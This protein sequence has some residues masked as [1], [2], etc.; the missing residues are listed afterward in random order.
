MHKYR[1][2]IFRLRRGRII[3]KKSIATNCDVKSN[4]SLTFCLPFLIILSAYIVPV[5]GSDEQTEMLG[6]HAKNSDFALTT[7]KCQKIN[8]SIFSE[9]VNI[10]ERETARDFSNTFL[11]RC[12]SGGFISHTSKLPNSTRRFFVDMPNWKYYKSESLRAIFAHELIHVLQYAR[13]GS[14]DN[15]LRA[16]QDDRRTVEVAADFGAGYLLSQ[17]AATAEYAMN[18][19]LSGQFV[20]AHRSTHGTPSERTQAFRLGLNFTRRVS[21]AFGLEKAEEYFLEFQ[22]SDIQ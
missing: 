17:T 9:L 2:V 13:H 15:V 10:L 8:D 3:H 14:F 19:E 6:F 11:R 16:Y 1:S 12:T 7:R 5:H 21:K 4:F 20:A 22:R 18:P